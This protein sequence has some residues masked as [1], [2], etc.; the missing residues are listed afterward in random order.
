MPC[1]DKVSKA[2]IL[3]KI[4]GVALPFVD[5]LR[6]MHGQW[7]RAVDRAALVHVHEKFDDKTSHIYTLLDELK[8]RL[9]STLGVSQD[10]E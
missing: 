4:N 1:K 2:E 10:A 8:D 6:H 7:D 3:L 5:V 9:E